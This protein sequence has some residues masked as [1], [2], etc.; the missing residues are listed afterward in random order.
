MKKNTP[1]TV[2]Y[3]DGISRSE[4]ELATDQKELNIAEAKNILEMGTLE[5]KGQMIKAESEVKSKQLSIDNAER[6]LQAAKFAVPFNVNSIL[7]A[8]AEVKQSKLD[9]ETYQDKLSQI[10]EAYDYLVDLNA[11]L[12]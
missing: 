9:M 6:K 10:K 3:A 12:F 11:E 1:T 7:S 4:S 5:V 8:R 2:K